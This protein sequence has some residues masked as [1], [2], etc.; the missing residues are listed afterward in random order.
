MPQKWDIDPTA[1]L[2]FTID[3]ETWLDGDTIASA[4]WTASGLTVVTSSNT[5][6]TASVWL[7]SGMA[8]TK[9]TATCHIVT[10]A[11]AEDSRTLTFTVK[12]R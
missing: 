10:A 2:L 3:W 11:G 5:V 6:T 4:A 9:A 7:S 12:H 1:K 8:G